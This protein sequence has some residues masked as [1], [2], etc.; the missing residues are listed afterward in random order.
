MVVA[1]PES[2]PR[3]NAKAGRALELVLLFVALPG[4]LVWL[5]QTG[6]RFPV[7][8]LLL[9]VTLGVWLLL[10]SD[11]SFERATLTRSAAVRSELA[12]IL[13][14]FLGCAAALA[15][16]TLWFEPELLF[17][18]PRRAPVTYLAVL[19]LYPLLSAYPQE[20]LYRAFFLHRYQDLFPGPR[21]ALLV[22]AVLF[23]AMHLIFGNALAVVLTLVGG[24]F[25][26]LTY[27][28]TRSLLA[29]TVE[30]ALYGCFVFTIGL[31]RY[32]YAGL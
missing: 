13:R 16:Y 9:L 26:G 14:V 6:T 7:I 3:R 5:R 18:F 21:A 1:Q 8:P 25:F 22:S 27:L 17:S 23:A 2:V 28:R 4:V 19:V 29:C 12:R 24:V 30:H 20:L 15:A 11:P 32:F 10:R 31:G